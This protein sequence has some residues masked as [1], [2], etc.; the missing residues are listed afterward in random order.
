MSACAG[1]I[2]LLVTFA[3]PMCKERAP[4]VERCGIACGGDGRAWI[5]VYGSAWD[6]V[7][8]GVGL[9]DEWVQANGLEE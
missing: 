8:G 4:V 9:F 1:T 7:S 6:P 2:A 5:L 3:L